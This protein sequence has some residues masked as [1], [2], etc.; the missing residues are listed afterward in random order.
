MRRTVLLRGARRRPILTLDSQANGRRS[1]QRTFLFLIFLTGCGPGADGPRLTV[2]YSTSYGGN[3]L[4]ISQVD[5]RGVSLRS[6]I[7]EVVTFRMSVRPV[8]RPTTRT[9]LSITPLSAPGFVI[10]PEHFEI[11]RMQRVAVS[12]VPGWHIRSIPPDQRDPNPFDALIPWRAAR[13]GLPAVLLPGQEYWFWVDV[14]V[15]KG[16]PPGEYAGR[17]SVLDEGRELVGV[18]VFLTVMPLVLPD[19]DATPVI[20]PLDHRA[21]MRHHLT[22]HGVPY[23]PPRDDWR[24]DPLHSEIDA[25][26][27]ETMRMLRAHRVT[28]TLPGVAPSTR[29]DARGMI[30]IDWTAYDAVVA[31]YLEGVGF[32][33]RRPVFAWPIPRS[34][35][36]MDRLGNHEGTASRR[37]HA[38]LIE[39]ARHFRARG[40]LD[41][42]FVDARTHGGSIESA[43]SSIGRL[44]SL[45]EVTDESLPVLTDWFPQDMTPYGWVGF[46]GESPA[47]LVDIWAPLAQFFDPVAMEAE[48]AAGRRTWMTVDRPPFGGTVRLGAPEGCILGLPWQAF[49]LGAQAMLLGT[50]NPWPVETNV[51]PE[52]CIDADPMALI[53]PGAAFGLSR[54]IPTVRLKLL[55]RAMYDAVYR[56]LLLQQGEGHIAHALSGSLVSYA[57]TQAYRAHFADGR[58]IGFALDPELYDTARSIM[59]DRLTAD[60]HEAASVE[61]DMTWRRFML[62]TRRVEVLQD[63]CRVLTPTA[64]GTFGLS[65]DCWITVM[66]QLRV[67]IEGNLRWE[68]LPHAWTQ[69]DAAQALPRIEPN[70]SRRHLLSAETNAF[71]TRGGQIALSAVLAT[72]A[73]LV[74]RFPLRVSFLSAEATERPPQIDGDLSDWT[75]GRLNVASDFR[76]ISSVAPGDGKETATHPAARTVAFVVR[77]SDSLYVAVNAARLPGM[78]LTYRSGNAIDYHDMIPVGEELIELLFDPLNAGTRSPSDLYHVIVKPSGAH[79]SERGIRFEPPCGTRRPWPADLRVATRMTDER[80]TVELRIPLAAFGDVAMDSAIWGFNVTRFDASSGQFSTWSGAVGNAY[81]PLSLGNLFLPVVAE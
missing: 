8:D 30:Q 51:D 57:G 63:G 40:W 29:V 31:P 73:G 68:L 42:A 52:F 4:E 17:V 27:G 15:P 38:A 61:H 20:A 10:D 53:Y 36:D 72:D 66:N 26:L 71:D 24:T 2:R 74:Q 59:A 64:V 49:R 14:R 80:W 33:D 11:Y 22:L 43:L 3:P 79:L 47:G 6:A 28:P 46:P 69:A 37:A 39:C 78:P 65:V 16:T 19:D 48:R 7:N 76:L 21:L 18:D 70:S 56:E 58:P 45:S 62:D 34:L 23:V 50:V 44:A 67:P 1:I 25:L 41:R 32:P 55:R 5:P 77:D 81:D 13:G 12:D 60:D 35:L 54:P 75:P 9:E